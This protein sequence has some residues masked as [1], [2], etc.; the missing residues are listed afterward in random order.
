VIQETGGHEL[1]SFLKSGNSRRNSHV[2]VFSITTYASAGRTSFDH[3][4]E[5][6]QPVM[7]N[8]RDTKKLMVK[9]LAIMAHHGDE[10]AKSVIE[11]HF[12]SDH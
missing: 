2:H 1:V 5:I 6:E 8:L 7:L 3:R 11:S 10:E 9:L 12:R 4:G